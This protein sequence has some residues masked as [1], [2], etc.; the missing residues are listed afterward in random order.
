[1]TAYD[2]ISVSRDGPVGIVTLDRPERMNAWTWQM[3]VEM[4]HA[5]AAFD[6]DDDVRAIVVT[7]AGRAFC[8]GA[9]LEPKGA[10]FDGSSGGRDRWADRYPG[11]SSDA[12]HLATPVIGAINGAAVGAGLTLAMPFDIRLVAEGAKLGFVFNRRGVM[13]DADLLWSLPRMIGYGRAMDLLLTG[14]IFTGR[15][16]FEIGLA[17]RALPTEDVLP[18]ALEL[19]HDLATNV[20]P[21][22]AAITKQLGRQ[23]LDETDGRAALARQRDLF[24]WTG[25]QPDAREGVEAFL[26][27]R[28]PRWSLS[29]TG[30]LPDE[31]RPRHLQH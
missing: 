20:A 1:M 16:A 22:S 24:A 27:K 21:V 29:K 25:R 15:E 30:D 19:A 14:R 2:T 4:A 10:T 31:V 5:Y 26:E 8:A 11:P 17:S 23:F 6:L 3:S 28:P 9:A 13:P 18:A 7:G 12:A